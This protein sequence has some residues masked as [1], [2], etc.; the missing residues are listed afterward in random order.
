M[1]NK[2][3]WLRIIEA[4]IA[5]LI[6]ASVLLITIT[7]A[8]KP[9]RTEEI[10][11]MQRSVLEQVASND[12]LREEIINNDATNTLGFI[13]SIIDPKW[14]ARIKI[15]E[16]SDICKM[17]DYVE[18]DVYVDEILISSTLQEYNPKVLKLFMWEK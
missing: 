7:N 16:I 9:D 3:A 10:Y 13:T 5:V 1:R 11:K 6:V 18:K 8:P 17:D 12:S 14:E 4:F 15:C 2:K